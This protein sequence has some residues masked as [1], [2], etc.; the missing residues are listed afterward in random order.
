M[1]L[2]QSSPQ[3]G[4]REGDI[5]RLPSCGR[6]VYAERFYSLAV[7]CARGCKMPP[8]NTGKVHCEEVSDSPRVCHRSPNNQQNW[9]GRS[10]ILSS[11]SADFVEDIR[12]R[13]AGVN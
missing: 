3:L 4:D 1:T 8:G 12:K 11:N 7:T 13:G 6:K 2:G 5:I 10:R 9:W